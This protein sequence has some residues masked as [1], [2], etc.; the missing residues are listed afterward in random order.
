MSIL[1]LRDNTSIYYQR[2]DGNNQKPTLVF[3]HEG[4][5]CTAMWKD[6]PEKLCNT[7]ESPGLVYDRLGYGRSSSLKFSR[8]LN[9]LHSY[10]LDELPRIIDSLIPGKQ[11]ILIGHSDGG[12]ISLIFAAEQPDNLKGVI[13]EASHVFVEP[14]TL[15][16]IKKADKAYEEG[17]LKVLKKYHGTKTHGIFK[18]WSD[19][20]LSSGFKNWNIERV[21]S[22]VIC[23]LLVIQG[24]E[25]QYGTLRQV[26][27]IVKGVTGQAESFLVDNCGHVPHREQRGQVLEKMSDFIRKIQ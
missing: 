24:C 9:Y 19:T 7:T 15:A 26:N 8:N 12:S 10:A 14:Q 6:F 27:S 13:T 17:K 25:D 16:G 18:A 20:W 2:I 4:L 23:P 11:F 1:N 22:S 3:L 21:L 5:G